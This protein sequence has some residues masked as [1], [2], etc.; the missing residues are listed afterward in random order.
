[1]KENM[2]VKIFFFATLRDYVGEKTLEM[3]FPE[4]IT[5]ANLKKTLLL[6]YP[7]MIR[8]QNSIMAAI[9]REFAAD[10]QVIPS[11]AEVAL[12]PPV[13]GG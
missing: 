6:R 8:A 10:E 1:M 5:V 4:G 9:N 7:K 13:S 3:E 2:K 11:D 12:F